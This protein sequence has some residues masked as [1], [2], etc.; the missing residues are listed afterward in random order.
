MVSINSGAGSVVIQTRNKTVERDA[1]ART[2]SENK[3]QTSAFYGN[4][5]S[6]VHQMDGQVPTNDVSRYTSFPAYACMASYTNYFCPP[7]AKRCIHVD[8]LGKP[9]TI[10]RQH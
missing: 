10:A 2:R 3:L 5:L 9:P 1:V 4:V 6:G 8:A 7:S